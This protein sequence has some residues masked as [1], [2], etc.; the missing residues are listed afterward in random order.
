MIVLKS[1]VIKYYKALLLKKKYTLNKNQLFYYF[2]H[3]GCTSIV[4]IEENEKIKVEFI[5]TK[6]NYKEIKEE[7]K[8]LHQVTREDY[9]PTLRFVQYFE[10]KD[11]TLFEKFLVSFEPYYELPMASITKQATE[12]RKKFIEFF[13]SPLLELGFERKENAW[14]I[15][16]SKKYIM[17]FEIVKTILDDAYNINLKI[18]PIENELFNCMFVR[19]NYENDYTIDY[20]LVN[21]NILEN[22]F[23]N[24]IEKFIK[25]ILSHTILELGKNQ[26]IQD[27]SSCDHYRCKRCWLPK[28]K[29]TSK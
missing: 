5:L 15:S 21:Y 3:E 4:K 13:S 6:R 22:I 12:K 29:K 7:N 17:T 25:P 9:F 23:N 24:L 10:G 2:I 28:T 27:H 26:L 11:T 14:N 20:Q 1:S 18:N 8:Y 16:L 19:L